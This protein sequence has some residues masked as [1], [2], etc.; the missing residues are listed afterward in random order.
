MPGLGWSRSQRS[1]D[2]RARSRHPGWLGDPVSAPRRSGRTGCENDTKLIGQ[3]DE[4]SP[5]VAVALGVL[6]DQLFDAGLCHGHG[7]Q[8]VTLFD[9][10]FG[11]ELTVQNCL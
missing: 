2:Y 3:R 10:N 5:G 8:L 6:G 4:I 9:G 11:I 1:P 7:Q